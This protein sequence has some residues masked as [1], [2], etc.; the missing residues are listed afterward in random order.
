M[1]LYQ[2]NFFT[3]QKFGVVVEP[4]CCSIVMKDL[5]DTSFVLGIPI[6]E[7]ILNVLFGYRKRVIS[8][9]LKMK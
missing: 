4:K 2:N 8:I 3:F 5:D 7:I 9:K 6:L 1:T